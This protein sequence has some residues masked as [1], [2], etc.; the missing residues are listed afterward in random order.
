MTE[1]T[2]AHN[3]AKTG[4]KD[5]LPEG[6]CVQWPRNPGENSAYEELNEGQWGWMTE[7]MERTQGKD[8]YCGPL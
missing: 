2:Y 5:F 7:H 1:A 3:E 6:T 4:K 8:E